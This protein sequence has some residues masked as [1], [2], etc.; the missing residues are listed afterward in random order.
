MN[1]P[2][3]VAKLTTEIPN[4]QFSFKPIEPVLNVDEVIFY[5]KKS[6]TLQQL[7][8]FEK[9]LNF[10]KS[11]IG[12][13]KVVTQN[14][15]ALISETLLE[16]LKN[17]KINEEFKV[18]LESSTKHSLN[19]VNENLESLFKSLTT[20]NKDENLLDVKEYTLIILGYA[21]GTL[22]KIYN[23]RNQNR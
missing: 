18:G 8:N 6:L 22:K 23:S 7:Q 16:A 19:S 9:G 2:E 1:I 17:S 21:I 14:F 11:N 13:D 3:S 5:I 4:D 10:F 20:L 15:I 12:S